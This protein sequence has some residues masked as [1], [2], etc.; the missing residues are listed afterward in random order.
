MSIK[1]KAVCQES[2]RI[3]MGFTPSDGSSFN[4]A[5]LDTL[6]VQAFG[7]DGLAPYGLLPSVLV[8]STPKLVTVVVPLRETSLRIRIASAA[9]GSADT[10][11]ETLFDHTFTPEEIRKRTKAD[12]R[13]RKRACRHMVDL[14]SCTLLGIPYF[15]IW[16]CRKM[17]LGWRFIV[18]LPPNTTPAS[19]DRFIVARAF[20]GFTYLL[21]HRPQTLGDARDI[22]EFAFMEIETNLDEFLIDTYLSSNPQSET[23]LFL[24]RDLIQAI[25]AHPQIDLANA[26]DLNAVHYEQW[27]QRNSPT[28]N[29]LARQKQTDISSGPLFS[30]VVPLFNTPLAFFNEMIASV[31]A[32]SYGRWQLVLVNAS[33][34]NESLY[35]TISDACAQD[36]RIEHVELDSNYGIAKNTALGVEHATGDFLCFLDHD[37]VL[38]PEALYEYA[39]KISDNPTIDLLYSDEDMLEDGHFCKPLLKPDFN[40]DLLRSKNYLI[41]FLAVRRS[42]YSDM[43]T[44]GQELDGAQDYHA[45]LYAAK[46]A[47]SICHVPSV[48][49]HWRSHSESTAIHAEA[50]PYAEQAGL[51]ALQMHLD[52]TC[53]HAKAQCT[54]YKN[55]Y[56]VDYS[57]TAAPTLSIIHPEGKAPLATEQVSIAVELIP[58]NNTD[59]ATFNTAAGQATGD[60]LLFLPYGEQLLDWSCLESLVGLA[61]RN[62]VGAV[63]GTVVDT[64]GIIR[65][66][67]YAFAKSTAPLPLHQGL[68]AGFPGYLSLAHTTQD[69]SGLSIH[70]LVT[71][72]DVFCRTSGFQQTARVDLGIDYCVSL[73]ALDLVCVFDATYRIYIESDSVNRTVPFM[74]CMQKGTDTPKYDSFFNANLDSTQPL[75]RLP[76]IAD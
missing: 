16:E 48:L 63:G 41:H 30:I 75:M 46:H 36:D 55:I 9:K 34:A 25:E 19:D 18:S 13:I 53:P 61:M 15:K 31:L 37:D 39:R 60:V 1:L 38:A 47:R 57:A 7:P 21:V 2:G 50:K 4:S 70:G 65:C 42:L 6:F 49:Y 33:P 43:P 12:G 72:K 71:R 68:P 11:A 56:W 52:R 59:Y 28:D 17:E 3:Y 67:G 8:S 66:A 5:F 74:A 44:V 29:E 62:D 26:Y 73:A 58:V 32:Q 22:P 45:A 51:R 76:S 69:V 24:F 40:L 54:E 20:D 14:S 10:H 23:T 64:E 35:K 27:L